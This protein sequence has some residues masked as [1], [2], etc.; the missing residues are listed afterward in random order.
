MAT[1]TVLT[2]TGNRYVPMQ[3]CAK[4]MARQ[5]R[6]PDR[7]IIVDDGETGLDIPDAEIMYR[8]PYGRNEGH[9][10]PH[11]ILHALPHIDTDI[12][13]FMED[14]DW[15]HPRYLERMTDLLADPS[16][17]LAGEIPSFYYRVGTRAWRSM[18]AGRQAALACTGLQR[19]A[20]PA[21]AAACMEAI[22][23]RTGSVD[24]HLWQAVTARDNNGALLFGPTRDNPRLCVGIK[25]LP[26][27]PGVTSGWTRDMTG[28]T[29]DPELSALRQ[30]I[31]DDAALY[32]SY[33][34]GPRL[35][36]VL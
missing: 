18:Y 17:V 35:R 7:W 15:Y 4:Y 13:V 24:L 29:A 5:T 19:L 22:Q 12:L 25:G 6:K 32:A 33:Y 26:G 2:C 11:N 9:T 23:R 20:Y 31:G 1:L 27:R 16:Y 21:L 14:D 8:T 10:L 3:L 36:P 34:N 28:Y 30:Q